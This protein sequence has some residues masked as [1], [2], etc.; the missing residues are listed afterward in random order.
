MHLIKVAIQEDRLFNH[1]NVLEKTVLKYLV[2][3]PATNLIPPS[4]KKNN[5]KQ[6]TNQ[7]ALDTE[8]HQLPYDLLNF[9]IMI[10]TRALCG[11]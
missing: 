2:P 8:E 1:G 7:L 11:K 9:Q 6:K 4:T 10:P 5:N 3:N